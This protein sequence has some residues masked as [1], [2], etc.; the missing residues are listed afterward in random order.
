MK[1]E[2]HL[3]HNF[4]CHHPFPLWRKY[5]WGIC[6][7]NWSGCFQAEALGNLANYFA[8]GFFSYGVYSWSDKN[9]NHFTHWRTWLEKIFLTWILDDVVLLWSPCFLRK[10]YLDIAGKG[11]AASVAVAKSW[12]EWTK[13]ACEGNGPQR[14]RRGIV[15][16]TMLLFCCPIYF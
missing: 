3:F 13:S 14:Q 1:T 5:E 16:L 6:C 11:T 2:K 12:R 15:W 9:G 8:S 10:G 7:V 4:H